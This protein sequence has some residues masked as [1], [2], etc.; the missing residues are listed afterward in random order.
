MQER[1]LSAMLEGTRRLVVL[2]IRTAGETRTDSV[3]CQ[4]PASTKGMET[5]TSDVLE[6]P[7]V[8]YEVIMCEAI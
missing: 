4:G 1:Y 2:C 6:S 7:V 5:D 8:S 3:S